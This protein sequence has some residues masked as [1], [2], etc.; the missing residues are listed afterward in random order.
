[1]ELNSLLAQRVPVG[2]EVRPEIRLRVIVLESRRWIERIGKYGKA[3]QTALVCH[4]GKIRVALDDVD[5]VENI[6][7]AAAT[8]IRT[9]ASLVDVDVFKLRLPHDGVGMNAGEA[10]EQHGL[11]LDQSLQ[12]AGNGIHVIGDDLPVVVVD[13]AEDSACRVVED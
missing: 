5:H 12:V 8:G 6:V 10:A 7:V 3:R 1:D 11:R 4:I 13:A 2:N 9:D